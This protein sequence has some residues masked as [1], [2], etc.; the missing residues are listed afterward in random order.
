M[1][2]GKDVKIFSPLTPLC[3]RRSVECRF[4]LGVPR[5]SGCMP[6]EVTGDV[7]R[8]WPNTGGLSPGDRPPNVPVHHRRAGRLPT[9]G[10]EGSDLPAPDQSTGG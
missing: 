1:L 9:L 5:R 10:L 2:T 3:E 7:F 4:G 6:R 8:S